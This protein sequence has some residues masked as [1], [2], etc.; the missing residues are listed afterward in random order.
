[1]EITITCVY[2]DD[3][4]EITVVAP[5]FEIAEEKLNVMQRLVGA[6]LEYKAIS[7]TL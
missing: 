1:M 7:E 2:A 5:S 6:K 3:E 4:P